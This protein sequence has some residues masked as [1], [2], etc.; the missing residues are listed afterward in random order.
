LAVPTAHPGTDEIRI[1]AGGADYVDVL[2]RVSRAA[3]RAILG[4]EDPALYQ[5][6]REGVFSYDIPLKPGVYELRLHFAETLYGESNPAG[7]GESSRVFNV[8]LN[9]AD[10]LSDF[11]VIADAGANTADIKVFKNVSPAPDG[12]LHLNFEEATNKPILNG[13]EIAPGIPGRLKPIR[14][15]TRNRSYIDKRGRYWMADRFS[16]GGQLVDRTESVV[17]VDDPEL[18]RSER[19]GNLSYIIPVAAGRYAATLYFSE[20]WFGPKKQ[21][22]GGVGSRLFDILCNGVPLARSYDIFEEAGGSNRCVSRTFH[23]LEPNHQGKLV[24]S[25]TPSKNYASI[26]A[27]EVVDESK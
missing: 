17:G 6:R 14:I 2:G 24:I 13:I 9:G 3:D 7:G 8:Q 25:L 4:A 5:F 23:N 21:V 12:K 15:V 18:F 27:L 20:S 19:F 11:D 1:L 16:R 10:A 26:N 22:G